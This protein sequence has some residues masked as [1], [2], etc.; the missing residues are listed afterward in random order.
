MQHPELWILP[1]FLTE[2]QSQPCG[3][4]GALSFIH[5]AKAFGESNLYESRNYIG[6][7]TVV[8]VR[9]S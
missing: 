9:D 3:E 8:T 7:V 2:K 4:S 5:V 1:P 6:G